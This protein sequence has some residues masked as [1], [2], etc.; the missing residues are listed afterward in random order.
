MGRKEKTH[1][2]SCDMKLS[3][4]LKGGGDMVCFDWYPGNPGHI[5]A[6][7]SMGIVALE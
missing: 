6:H 7:L 3:G 4:A 2:N 5:S 1:S